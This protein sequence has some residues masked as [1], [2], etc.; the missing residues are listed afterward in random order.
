MTS[1]IGNSEEFQKW[2]RYY[3]PSGT[4]RDINSRLK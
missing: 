2:A 1:K 3:D 4:L